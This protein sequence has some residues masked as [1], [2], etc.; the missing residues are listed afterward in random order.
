MTIPVPIVPFVKSISFFFK[1]CYVLIQK[2]NQSCT[3]QCCT[4]INFFRILFVT[5]GYCK[6][7]YGVLIGYHADH[8]CPAIDGDFTMQRI[9]ILTSFVFIPFAV[10]EP[11]DCFKTIV[12]VV[13][14]IDI[15]GINIK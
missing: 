5:I 11:A 9:W 13:V 1:V 15:Q 6:N 2:G 10:V 14:I 12:T 4:S 8:I 3:F 7:V